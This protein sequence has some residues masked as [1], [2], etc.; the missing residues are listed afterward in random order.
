VLHFRYHSTN[1]FFIQSSA[2]DQ[3]L[4][5]DA[6]WPGTLY[7]YARDMKTIGCNL[8]RIG[9][10]IVTHF[11]MD[12]AGLVGEFIDRGIKCFAFENQQGVI[13][14]MERTIEKTVKAYR[15]IDQRKLL[16]MAT[17]DSRK[18]LE[19]M[20]VHGQ[21]MVTDYHSPDSISFVSDEGEAIVGDLPPLGQMMPGDHRLFDNWEKLK[22]MGARHVY[23]SHAPAFELT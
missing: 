17:G 12:H 23:P 8:E 19:E 3:I 21:I 4:S 7:E 2:G 16:P 10:A 5:I 14:S 20:G 6:G 11:H 13:D 1:C 9:W 18:M 22:R 15:R